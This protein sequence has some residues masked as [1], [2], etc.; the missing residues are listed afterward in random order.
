M[1][2][3]RKQ[4]SGQDRA[5]AGRDGRQEIF[6][7][8]VLFAALFLCLSGYI[9]LYAA[10]HEE[11]LI[12]NAYNPRQKILQE[13]N[14]RGVIYAADGQVLAEST[15]SE[16]GTVRRNYPF[17]SLFAHAVGYADHGRMGVEAQMNYYLINSGIPFAR[18][19][20]NERAGV[21]NPGDNVYTTLR[22]DLQEAAS[23]AMGVVYRGAVVAM[24]PKTGEIYAMVSKPDF[25]PNRIGDL[26]EELLADT[27]SGTLVNR[28]SQ[29]LYP[30]GSTF[31]I[32]TTLEY[33]REHPDDFADYRYTCNG[34]ITHGEDTIRCYH[35]SVHGQ[36]DLKGSFSESC[37]TSFA[38][39]G[40]SLDRE[41]FA[42]TLEQLG[43]NQK[44]P[45]D[46]TTGVS[47]VEVGADTP[48]TEMMQNAIGQG[49]TQMTP[50]HLAMLTSAVANGG[51]MMR[52]YLVTGVAT[53]EG[54][55]VRRIE[56]KKT[57][58]VLSEQ[59]AATLRSYMEEV[60]ATG[61]G[62]KLSG[63]SYTAAGKTGSAE[64]N[65]VKGESHSWFTG[66]APADDPEIVV[67]VILEGAGSGA[68]YAVP[69]AKRVL[70]SYFGV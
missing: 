56:P 7:V 11:D 50:L 30:P 57:G 39:I 36:E 65:T 48:D 2:R 10:T 58:T 70:D 13:Q 67:T 44:L 24:N 69:I 43:F 3:S 8:T 45:A 38:N 62:K 9:I 23:E 35:G 49:K 31:K 47:R 25:D 22:P 34:S 37:N 59:E 14:L 53:A 61:T 64:Y 12:N 46:F 42:E 32:V 33:I 29:G 18:K 68:D 63:L 52:P 54:T 55:A 15:V 66:Y 60:V 40:L 6:R 28:V 20:E 21:R 51:T 4:K 27:E 19:V 41:T 16:D 1:E 17:G 26:W 5:G